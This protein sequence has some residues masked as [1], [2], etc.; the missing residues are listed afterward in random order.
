MIQLENLTKRYGSFVAVDD[1]TLHVPRGVLYGFLGP[2]GAND[3][4]DSEQAVSD[5]E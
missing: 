1:L 5:A 3:S 2:N 4:D